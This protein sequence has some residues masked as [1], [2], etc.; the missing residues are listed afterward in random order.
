MHNYSLSLEQSFKIL[1]DL[2]ENVI[3]FVLLTYNCTYSAA[4]EWENHKNAHIH[5]VTHAEV[6]DVLSRAWTR[7]ARAVSSDKLQRSGM[8]PP[9]YCM[10]PSLVESLH[11]QAKAQPLPHGCDKTF[12]GN[13]RSKYEYLFSLHMNLNIY[14][15]MFY[16]YILYVYFIFILCYYGYSA[17][18]YMRV[19]YRLLSN[20]ISVYHPVQ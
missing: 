14:V 16:E 2:N 7:S 8:T 10:F 9:I 12:A 11:Y 18:M 13:K 17:Q 4:S 6:L 20:Y 1:A 5:K 3:H 15:G 19:L